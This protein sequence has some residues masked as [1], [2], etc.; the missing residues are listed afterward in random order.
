MTNGTN[1]RRRSDFGTVRATPR[2]LALLQWIGEQFAVNTAQ[3]K[4]LMNRWKRIHE[5][6]WEEASISDETVKWILKRWQRPGWVEHRKL[7]ARQPAWVWLSKTGL[8]ELE[9][10]YPPHT[11]AVGR[12]SHIYHVNAVRLH[13]EERLGESARWISERQI[14][15]ERK[16]EGKR[17]LVDGELLYQ[18]TLIGIE[19]EQTQKSRRRLDSIL[20]ELQSDYEAVWY[21][22]ADTA[23]PAVREAIVKCEGTANPNAWRTFVIYSL[24][25]ATATDS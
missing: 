10:D 8:V 4:R 22:V 5:P 23:G 2:D 21:F 7:L 16:A 18:D 15:V 3:L 20:K 14:N 19:V 25:E 6:E 13:I 24:V 9:L 12:L 17:H 1:N 11:P